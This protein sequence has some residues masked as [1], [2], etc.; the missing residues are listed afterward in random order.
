M[1]ELLLCIIIIPLT[2]ALS[3]VII[4]ASTYGMCTLM[5]YLE[6]RKYRG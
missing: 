2:I 5:S 4:G 1:L 6:E 3:I